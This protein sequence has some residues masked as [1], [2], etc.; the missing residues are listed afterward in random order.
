M[1]RT[2]RARYG[3]AGVAASA[4]LAVGLGAGVAGAKTTKITIEKPGSGTITEAGSSLL[5]PLWNLWSPGYHAKY[6][7]LNVNTAAGGSGKG[8]SE[9]TDGTIQ[10]GASDA[11][12][13]PTQVQADPTLENIPLAISA[14]EIF[15]NVTGV[16]AH[17]K[18]SGK[19]LASI[20]EGKVT[21]WSTT[22][23]KKLNPTAT[24]PTLPIVTLHRLDSSGDTFLFTSY[25]SATTSTWSTK[26]G[27][28]TAITWPSAPGALAE[29]GNSGMVA[30]CKATVG[31][32]AYVGISYQTQALGDGLTYAQLQNGKGQYE[33]PTATTIAAEANGFAKKT[34]KTG[35]VS[36]I[37]GK[38]AGGYPIV[39]Y[40]YAIV[41]KKQSSATVA[42]DVR[43]LLEWC[44]SPAGG[45]TVTYLA[46]VN[47]RVL[48]TTVIASS[49]KQIK[50]IK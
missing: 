25:L 27:E 17:L 20:Y 39:N 29:S 7:A 15:Y 38:V 23:I 4:A 45:Q 46:Q 1:L 12:L 13:A 47:F 35:S 2:H 49:Y 42:K 37:S 11:Y 6:P 18:L 50:A 26:P 21:K 36:M 9:A 5:Y 30:G 48:P 34:P 44:I 31:C 28:N 16:T 14:Q 33:L 32:I 8:I 22:A 10:I 41:Q 43:S 3:L 24:L 19:L 40:E